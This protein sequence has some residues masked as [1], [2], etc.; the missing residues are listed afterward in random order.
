MKFP[1]K[2]DYKQAFIA[3]KNNMTDSHREMLKAQ[4][5][6]P[7]QIITST[8]LAEAAGYQHYGGAN[9]QY[10]RIGKMIAHHLNYSP[11]K[12]EDN[13]K[14]FWSLILSYGYWRT[15]ENPEKATQQEWHWQLRSQVA[16]ALQELGWM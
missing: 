13:G 16:Q 9:L 8:K 1:S 2:E 6:A 11:P 7:Q 4:Y 12:R 5:H 3:I 14:P 10:A 15:I